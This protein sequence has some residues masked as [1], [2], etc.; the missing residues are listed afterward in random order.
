MPEKK[1]KK[2]IISP[3]G[4]DENFLFPKLVTIWSNESVNNR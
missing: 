1:K 2:E 3:G 4:L